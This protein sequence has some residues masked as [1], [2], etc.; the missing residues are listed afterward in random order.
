MKTIQEECVNMVVGMVAHY[1]DEEVDREALWNALTP[2]LSH[3]QKG[4]PGYKALKAG[5]EAE[6]LAQ[7]MDDEV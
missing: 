4:S 6:R 2:F 3:I 7:R 1:S 5:C